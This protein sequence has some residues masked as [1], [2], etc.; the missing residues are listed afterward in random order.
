LD[1]FLYGF[2]GKTVKFAAGFRYPWRAQ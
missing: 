2:T 1:G